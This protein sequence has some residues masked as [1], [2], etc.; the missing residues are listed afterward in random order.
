MNSWNFTGNLGRDHE[1]RQD[2]GATI[3]GLCAWLRWAG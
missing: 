2:H 1:L 3:T